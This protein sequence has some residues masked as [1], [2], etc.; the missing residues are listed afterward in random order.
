MLRELSLFAI[1]FSL[2]KNDLRDDIIHPGRN[3]DASS[4]EIVRKFG[5]IILFFKHVN[6]KLTFMR[7]AKVVR[8][9]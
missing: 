4:G 9:G 2:R 6:Q 3:N 8:K 5:K 1:Q 7:T